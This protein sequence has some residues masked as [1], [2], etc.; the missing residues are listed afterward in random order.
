MTR[1]MVPAAGSASAMVSGM[2]SAPSPRRTMTNWPGWRICGDARG[3]DVQPGD[4]RAELG[5][6]DDLMH[7]GLLKVMSGQNN[8]DNLRPSQLSGGGAGAG[9]F[10]RGN[11]PG[12]GERRALPCTPGPQ[13][14]FRQSNALLWS[15]DIFGL[16]NSRPRMT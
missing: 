10:G 12:A 11:A 4:V 15:L 3:L 5:F 6:G 1:A 9:G 7:A 2:R 13:P 16:G 8:V 14:R